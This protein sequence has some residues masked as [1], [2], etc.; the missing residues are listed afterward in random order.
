[1]SGE[2]RSGDGTPIFRHEAPEEGWVAP[3]FDEACSEA[4]ERWFEERFGT[5]EFVWH[6]II[7]DRVHLD[8]HVIRPTTPRAGSHAP[9]TA[10]PSRSSPWSGC[11]R[12]R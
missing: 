9:T 4:V 7:S 10:A 6:E 8:V 2:E 11:T 1:M 3:E 5:P 12:T